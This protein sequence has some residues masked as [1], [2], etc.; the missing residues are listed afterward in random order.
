MLVS[1]SGFYYIAKIGC[2]SSDTI[3]YYLVILKSLKLLWSNEGKWTWIHATE[4]KYQEEKGRTHLWWLPNCPRYG[5]FEQKTKV[6]ENK[7]S[8]S[9]VS[10]YIELFDEFSTENPLF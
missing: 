3:R 4:S 6:K 10:S 8:A 1:E 5:H 9:L 2:N 7:Y